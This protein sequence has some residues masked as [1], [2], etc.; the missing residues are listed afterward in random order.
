VQGYILAR[1][2]IMPSMMH[3]AEQG[4]KEKKMKEKKIFF[5]HASMYQQVV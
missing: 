4:K 3:V 5:L 1:N 2:A